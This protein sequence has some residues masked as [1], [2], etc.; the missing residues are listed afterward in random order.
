MEYTIGIIGFGFVGKA[1][2]H[3]FAQTT[4]F[5]INDVDPRISR[6]TVEEVTKESDFIFICVPTPMDIDTCE[7]DLSIMDSVVDSI[8]QYISDN[9]NPI[10]LIKSTAVPGTTARYQ[11]KY[12]HMRFI[13]NPEFLTERTFKLDFINQSRIVLGGNP[14]DTHEIAKLYEI[15]F[16]GT[17]IFHTTTQA[18]E[19]I[20]YICNCFFAVKVSYFNEMGQVCEKVGLD[21]DH[22]SHPF[23]YQS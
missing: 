16:P 20:K 14:E 6:H 11:D 7:A 4:D 9:V 5:R 3:G 17:P 2:Q 15:R 21:Y 19:L 22:P 23:P 10:I 13:F 1:I 8:S 18:A 12:P